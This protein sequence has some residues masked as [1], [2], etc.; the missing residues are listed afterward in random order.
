MDPKAFL[1][2]DVIELQDTQSRK[3]LAELYADDYAEATSAAGKPIS[4]KL[5][6]EH[7]ALE[8]MWSDISYKLD[9][10][11]NAHFTPKMVSSPKPSQNPTIL[12]NFTIKPKATIANIGNVASASLESALPT[13]MSAST[14]LAPE[15]VF[16]HD[17]KATKAKSEMTPSEKRSINKKVKHT[18]KNQQQVLSGASVKFAG[19]GKERASAAAGLSKLPKNVK[20]AKAAAL[21][22]LVKTGKGVTVVGKPKMGA[23]AKAQISNG[24]SS[25]GQF[26]L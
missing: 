1:P 11:S 5:A 13:T 6:Q 18:K 17:K 24:A 10:L 16:A 8:K 2:K 12:T 23:G 25:G 20:E 26:K 15:E 19:V 14:L 4:G 21:D 7:E 22:A 3:S 9:A